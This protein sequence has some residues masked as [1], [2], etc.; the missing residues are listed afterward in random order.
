MQKYTVLVFTSFVICLVAVSCTGAAPN[1]T[2]VGLAGGALEPPNQENSDSPTTLGAWPS[3]LPTDSLQPWEE[4]NS[5]GYAVPAEAW[6]HASSSLNLESDFTPGV[7]RFSES[8]EVADYGEASSLG[9]G[10]VGDTQLS[11]A[12]YRVLGGGSPLGIVSADVNLHQR[13]DSSP[14]EYFLGVANYS[15]GAWDWHGPFTD[16]HVRLQM[17]ASDYVSGLGNYF[18]C[19]AAYDGSSFDVVGIGVNEKDLADSTPPATPAA[20][21]I[22]NYDSSAYLEWIGAVDADLAGY[23]VYYHGA[24]F[25]DGSTAGLRSVDYLIGDT[26]F[27]LTGVAGK[28]Y[29]RVAAVDVSGNESGLSEMARTAAMSGDSPTALLEVDLASGMLGDVFNLIATGGA[30]YDF[31]LDGDGIFDLM[32]NTSGEATLNA[33][34]TGI[35]R[36]LVRANSADGMSIAMGAVSLIVAGNSRPLALAYCAPASGNAPLPVDFSGE[37]IDYDGSIVGYAWDFEGD[38][39][40]DYVHASNPNPP[41][42]VYE[43]GGVYNAKFRVLD[44]NGA[45]DVDTVAVQVK[46]F[47]GFEWS[48]ADNHTGQLYPDFAIVDGNPAFAYYENLTSLF[49]IRASNPT[50]TQWADPQEIDASSGSGIYCSLAI[51]NGV[52]AVAYYDAGE[53][54]NFIYA[55]DPQGSVWSTPR[56]VLELAPVSGKVSLEV[57]DGNPAVG[58]IDGGIGWAKYIRADS[59]DGSTWGNA[60]V[61]VDNSGFISEWIDLEVIDGNPAIA[62]FDSAKAYYMRAT[63]STGNVSGNWADPR[64]NVSGVANCNGWVSLEFVNGRPA[65]AYMEVTATPIVA[66]H[67]ALNS[68]GQTGLDWPGGFIEVETGTSCGLYT[69]LG[70]VNGFPVVSFYM[71]EGFPGFYYSSASNPDGSAWNNPISLLDGMTLTVGDYGVVLEHNNAPYIGCSNLSTSQL[72]FGR[73]VFE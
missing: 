3:A 2:A 31:D 67:R 22:T 10:M 21:V 5:D 9:S 56:V 38:G 4:L 41:T 37:G 32:G 62:Y 34:Q 64:V 53:G 26:K 29:I 65:V 49:Y 48:H 60:A 52:P 25:V 19:V 47:V 1:P 59:V 28:T 70:V 6:T 61:T 44:N 7:E 46:E 43:A 42:H 13:S 69:S 71:V 33:T 11:Y 54:L 35:I 50:G 20:L 18:I 51:I 14:S 24:A 8:G 63:T 39:S 40:W 16:S 58:Y 36:P 17:Q 12:I 57:V 66:Y 73:P 55:D 15:K 72:F 27:L 30:T 23:R 68:T 45:W